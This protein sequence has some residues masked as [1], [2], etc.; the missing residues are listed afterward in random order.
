MASNVD[1]K[2][3]TDWSH[4]V[5]EEL[6]RLNTNFDNI[7]EKMGK[8]YNDLKESIEKNQK[9][10]QEQVDK[11]EKMLTGNGEPSKGLIV[12]VDRL[13]EKDEKN[14]WLSKATISAFISAIVSAAIGAVFAWEKIKKN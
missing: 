4:H 14:Q 10:M 5:L 2:T 13:A 7:N 11:L 12:R 3:W 1:N 9:E 6:I 8:N